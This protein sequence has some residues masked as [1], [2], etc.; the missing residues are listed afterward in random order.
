MKFFAEALHTLGVLNI[1]IALDTPSSADTAALFTKGQPDAVLRHEG[2]D[3][4]IPL[5]GSPL[6]SQT[7]TFP[8]GRRALEIRAPMT[9]DLTQHPRIPLLSA[10]VIQ[11]RWDNDRHISC[12]ACRLPVVVD[13]AIRWK[14]LPSQSWIEFSDYWHCHSG[15]SHPHAHCDHEVKRGPDLPTLRAFP[16]TAFVGL[17]YLVFNSTDTQHVRAKVRSPYIRILLDLKKTSFC[18]ITERS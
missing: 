3:I 8:P 7:T 2:E 14:E 9:K 11:S 10:E 13:H 17:I 18:F 12:R 16:G 5:P 4:R 6:N 15:S 1:S